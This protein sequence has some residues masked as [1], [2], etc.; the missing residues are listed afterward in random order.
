MNP[1]IS[2]IIPVYNVENELPDCLESVIHQSYK[3][4]EVILV[5]DGS[6][7]QSGKI[8]DKYALNDHRVRTIHK[9]NGGQSEARNIAINQCNGEYIVF[10]DSDDIAKKN[11]IESLL[12]LINKYNTLI[13]C[14]PY[15]KFNNKEQLFDECDVKTGIEDSEKAVKQ[16]LYQSRVFH[17][18]PHG[19]IYKRELFN[20]IEYPVGLYY[21]DLATTYKLLAKAS[22]VAFTTEKMYGYRIRAVSTMRQGF[23]SKKMSCIAVSQDLYIKVIEMYPN[24]KN[25]VGSRAFNVNRAVYLQIPRKYKRERD[26][27]WEEMK[28]YRKTV[29][30]DKEARKRERLMAL[31]SYLGQPFF[32]ILSAPY[33]RQQMG[34]Q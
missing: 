18:G 5:D 23:S 9:Q 15:Q 32:S 2:V 12:C 27:V 29:I 11:L 6:T 34:L 17:T 13:A 31:L 22:K 21:E 30:F 1:L 25:A 19:K 26:A 10:V 16:L 33:Q 8:C 28:K 7:D 14:S 20:G 4:I 24:L 3:N